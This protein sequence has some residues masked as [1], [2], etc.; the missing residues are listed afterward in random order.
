MAYLGTAVSTFT[1]G[2]MVERF[3]WSVTIDTW[4]ALTA[5]ALILCLLKRK[6]VFRIPA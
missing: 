2:V 4:V 3:G 1:I 5:A 6:K